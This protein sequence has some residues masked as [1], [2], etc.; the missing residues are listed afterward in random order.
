[1][2]PYMGYTGNDNGHRK[3]GDRLEICKQYSLCWD[4]EFSPKEYKTI[5]GI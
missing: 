4:G 1:M 3:Y 2:K 5:Q